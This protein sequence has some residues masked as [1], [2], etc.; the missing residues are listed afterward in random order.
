MKFLISKRPSDWLTKTIIPLK[1]LPS[2]WLLA[3]VNLRETSQKSHVFTWRDF[4]FHH[5]TSLII[6][7]YRVSGQIENVVVVC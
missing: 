2:P 5:F 3:S 4:R 6:V 1:T 7:F